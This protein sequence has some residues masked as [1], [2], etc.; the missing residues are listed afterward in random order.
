MMMKWR[1]WQIAWQK[2]WAAASEVMVAVSDDGM[3][4]VCRA[5]D[6]R[7]PVVRPCRSERFRIVVLLL[8]I[9]IVRCV[10]RSRE[11]GKER[12]WVSGEQSRVVD[13]GTFIQQR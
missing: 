5:V 11:C 1:E 8:Q 7:V 2:G 3:E 10:L 13:N 12:I 4:E 6:D 9:A